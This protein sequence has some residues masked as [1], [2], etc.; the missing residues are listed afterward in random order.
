MQNAG[1]SPGEINA[2]EAQ[3]AQ[4]SQ[5]GREAEALKLW[6]RILEIDPIH[7]RTLTA[8]GQHAFRKGDFQSARTAFQRVVDADGADPQQWI[9]LALACR[10]L[11]DEAG[12]RDRRFSA[13]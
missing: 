4:A 12:R 6:S 3:A 10:Q 11:D 8:V 9:N 5:S 2:L 1:E 7:A 13:R